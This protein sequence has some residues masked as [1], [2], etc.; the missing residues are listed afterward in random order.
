M[1][2]PAAVRRKSEPRDRGNSGERGLQRTKHAICIARIKHSD[3][4]AVGVARIKFTDFC[5][6]CIA[7]ISSPDFLS[8]IYGANG[9]VVSVASI[10]LT[11]GCAS[12][13]HA[14]CMPA[15]P[16]SGCLW[17]INVCCNRI[18]GGSL[19]PPQPCD[20]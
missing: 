13:E 2:E 18:E 5:A 8:S 7:S 15:S 19:G 17:Y 14:F 6:V 10:Q 1:I 16:C 12:I 20:R 11:H 3:Y 4:C 9:I